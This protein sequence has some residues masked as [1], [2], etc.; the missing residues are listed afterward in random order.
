MTCHFRLKGAG[1]VCCYWWSVVLYLLL[2]TWATAVGKPATEDLK[3]D[4]AA[5]ST[6][7]SLVKDESA[8]LAFLADYD[9]RLEYLTWKSVVASWNYNTNISE[10]TG[11]ISGYIGQE[12][13][14][15]I[16]NGS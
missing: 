4:A 6:Q 14:N 13:I 12:V 5:K 2:T 8:A 7:D 9:G 3:S 15:A 11:L 16:I 1:T 10:F